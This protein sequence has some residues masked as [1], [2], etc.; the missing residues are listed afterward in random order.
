MLVYGNMP[1]DQKGWDG[2]TFEYGLR[3]TFNLYIFKISSWEYYGKLYD[4]Y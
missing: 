1:N 3:N 2:V 4:N